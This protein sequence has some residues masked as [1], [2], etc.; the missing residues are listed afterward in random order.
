MLEPDNMC[1]PPPTAGFSICTEDKQTS[2]S[3]SEY[4]C[5]DGLL[6]C[7]KSKRKTKT[8][9]GKKKHK[10]SELF[11]IMS[12]KAAELKG[13]LKSLKSETSNAAVFIV[14]DS[15]GW[16]PNSHLF[17]LISHPFS[18]K[19]LCPISHLFCPN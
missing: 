13:K 7:N 12:T 5:L 3:N 14:Q 17:C 1:L 19:I 6:N 11:C 2:S 16:L 18:V 4:E 8:R 15:H 10:K 9:R